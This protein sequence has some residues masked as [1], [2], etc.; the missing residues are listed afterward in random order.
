MTARYERSS[1]FCQRRSAEKKVF[2]RRPTGVHLQLEH[3]ACQE[4]PE[5]AGSRR[6]P[7]LRRRVLP[8]LIQVPMLMDTMAIIALS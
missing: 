2:K 1:L 6:E 4:V 7:R 5:G 8:Q 3:H